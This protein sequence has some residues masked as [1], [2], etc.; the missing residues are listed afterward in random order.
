LLL[1][2]DRK[3]QTVWYVAAHNGELDVLQELLEVA[4]ENLT[5][6]KIKNELLLATES[7]GQ[8]PWHVA[9]SFAN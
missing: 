9:A 4:K 8:T 2:T 7:N 3:G 6:E 5:T 1:G